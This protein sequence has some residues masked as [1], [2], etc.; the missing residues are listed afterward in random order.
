MIVSFKWKL[1]L[2]VSLKPGCAGLGWGAIVICDCGWLLT[3]NLVSFRGCSNDGLP[4]ENVSIMGGQ[5]TVMGTIFTFIVYTSLHPSSCHTQYAILQNIKYAEYS[6]IKIKL[7]WV[8]DMS[9]V[10]P[11]TKT[12]QYQTAL[13][14][15]LYPSLRTR[16]LIPN[17]SRPLASCVFQFISISECCA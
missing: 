15:F 14:A 16:A 11:N 12:N 7:L 13:Q 2:I 4:Q 10:Y 6:Q 9:I 17:P 5:Q 8:Y 3:W 1:Q